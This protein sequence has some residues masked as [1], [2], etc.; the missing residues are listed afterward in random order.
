MTLPFGAAD[1]VQAVRSRPLPRRSLR[2]T[3]VDAGVVH[4]FLD[5]LEAD[6]EIEPHS[7]MLVHGGAVVAEGWWSP[8]SA[9]RVH[10]LYS[11]SK[12]VTALAVGF[13]VAERRLT[14]DDRIVDHFPEFADEVGER[15]RAIRIR[16]A[17]AMATGHH[18]DMVVRAVSADPHEP[19]RGFLLHEPESA[20]GTWFTYNQPAIYA[21]AAALQRATGYTLTE[22]LRPR[23]FD[24]VG[25]GPVAWHEHPAGRSIGFSGLHA[26]T[27][28]VATLGLLLLRD[29]RWQGRQLLPAGWVADLR[30][31]RFIPRDP[32][33]DWRI[34]YGYQVWVSRHGYRGD[35]A[36]GQFCLVL[37]EQD[38]VLVTT[39][40]TVR[41]QAVLEAVWEILVP[42]LGGARRRLPRQP[43]TEDHDEPLHQ[44]LAGLRLPAS[45]GG[46]VDDRWVGV[47]RGTDLTV[48]I[49]EA[50]R[51][52]VC[53][54]AVL[55]DGRVTLTVPI[56]TGNH[57][58]VVEPGP[59][60]GPGVS[61]VAVSGGVA[62]SRD[63]TPRLRLD[64]AFLES[65]HRL[66]VDLHHSGPDRGV[67]TTWGTAPLRLTDETLLDRGARWPGA[68]EA[69]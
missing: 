23:L 54:T 63:G 19:V 37:P 22:Y 59:C 44:R 39:M 3:G 16:D 68:P 15:S 48:T 62:A 53:R 45:V 66:Y 43:R 7:V 32:Y 57:W 55:H 31:P 33:P 64:L 49:P 40:G 58:A 42:A 51:S 18:R 52:G 11:L 67:T 26:T 2:A 61:P 28:D 4:R 14:L 50:D 12:T 46:P 25:I 20:P 60:A 1:P 56:G 35:G 5:V 27:E 13:A 34:G 9:D 24:P 8:Y 10:H 21:V 17:L 38:A 29:G 30:R 41:T 69:R 6:P 47:H 65:P 36:Y